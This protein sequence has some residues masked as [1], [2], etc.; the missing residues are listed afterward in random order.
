MIPLFHDFQDER[1][2]VIGGG[3]VAARK[4][5]TFASEADVDV[6]APSF[7][8]H[9]HELDC[10]RVKM[11]VDATNIDALIDDVFL[12]IPATD[13]RSLN[14]EIAARARD[15][16]LLVNRVDT[17]GET[18]SPSVVETPSLTVAISTRGRSPA[19]CKYLRDRLQSEAQRANGMVEIQERLR[20]TLA[21]RSQTERRNALWRVLD[22]EEVWDALESGEFERANAL[23]SYVALRTK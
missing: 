12:V 20:E 8:P 11:S 6:I 10:S 16:G 1:V 13:D 5:E 18:I 21:N 14:D 17:V 9:I 19:V 2:V 7:H 23:A 22:D 4:A 15:D 3:P